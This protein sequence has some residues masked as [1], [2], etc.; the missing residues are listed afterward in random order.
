MCVC[1]EVVLNWVN[2]L[3]LLSLAVHIDWLGA[4]LLL[5]S[6]GVSGREGKGSEGR[7]FIPTVSLA[8]FLSMWLAWRN[9]GAIWL[10][11]LFLFL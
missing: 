7:H 6:A 5:W 2:G 10:L 8:V 11:D 1:V 9:A 4:P 3:C